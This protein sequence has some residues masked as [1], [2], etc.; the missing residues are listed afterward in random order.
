MKGKGE[1]L[2]L[3]K[4]ECLAGWAGVEGESRADKVCLGCGWV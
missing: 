1:V 2:V 4:L 3:L